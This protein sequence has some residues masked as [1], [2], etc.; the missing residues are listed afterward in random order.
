[1]PTETTLQLAPDDFTTT[2]NHK[3]HKDRQL[4]QVNKPWDSHPEHA[5]QLVMAEALSLS[6]HIEYSLT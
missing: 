4:M 5:D 1:M 2:K 3:D 6:V